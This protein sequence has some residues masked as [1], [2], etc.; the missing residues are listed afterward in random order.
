MKT[1]ETPSNDALENVDPERRGFLTKILAGTVA[2]PVMT[3]VALGGPEQDGKGK[4]GRGKGGQGAKGKG[5][6]GNAGSQDGRGGRQGQDRDP[7]ETAARWIREFDK[8]G[9][10]KLNERELTAALKA[11]QERRASG[12]NSGRGKGKGGEG[13]GKGK[14]KGAGKGKGKGAG[15]GKGNGDTGIG[16]QGVTPRRPGK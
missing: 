4:G 14:G 1:N 15:K 7:A 13:T 6:G 12:E 2:L 10:G 3:S 16:S 9:D 5:K 11:M 8:D